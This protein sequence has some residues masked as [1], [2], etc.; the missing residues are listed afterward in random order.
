MGEGADAVY[1]GLKDFNARMRS[2]NFTYSQFEG[3]LRSIHR[4]GRKLYVTVNTVF[5]QR[6][7]DRV[8]QLLKY[9]SSIGPDGILVQDFGIITMVRDNFPSLKLHASTQ[10]NVSSARGV[11]LLSR[12]GFS[13]VVLARE[14]SLEEI[15]DIRANTN[16][17]LE[18]FVHGALCMSVSGLCLFSSYLGGKSANRGMCTQACRRYYTAEA[19]SQLAN[20]GNGG[21]YYFSP[22]DLEL[23]GEVPELVKAGVNSFKI[24]GRMKSA[25]YVG[26]VV[27]AYRLVLDAL[28]NQVMGNLEAGENSFGQAIAK[29][30]TIL[31]ND[32]A[33][34]KT[35]YFINGSENE[36]KESLDWLN[37]EQNGGTGIPLG[38]LLKVRRR[39]DESRGLIFAETLVP[40]VGDSIRL[41]KAD[42]SDRVSYKINAVEDC[43]NGSRWV[44][45]PEGFSPG[46]AVYLIQTKA[47]TRRYAPV[48]SRIEKCREPGREKA[49]LP[50]ETEEKK[51][52]GKDERKHMEE[53]PGGFYA[54]VSRIEDLYVLQSVR[55]IKVILTYSRKIIRQLLSGKPLP[56]PP[57]DIII[58]LDP[59]F[60]QAKNG[61]LEEGIPVL[62]AKGYT[63]F[64]VNNP[65]H[66]SLFRQTTEAQKDQAVLIAGPWL[67]SFNAWARSFIAKCGAEYFISPLENNRQ[68][69]EKTFYQGK[70]FQLG[71]KLPQLRNKVFITIFARPAL[72]R[73]HADLGSFYNFENFAGVREEAFRLTPAADGS[74]V[75]PCDPF[76]I[77]DK[78]P[79]LKE[80]GF[81][82]FILD[83]SDKPLKKAEY[84]N[85]MEAV[86]RAAPLPGTNRFNWKN[87]F[88]KKET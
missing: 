60:P 42:D 20:N 12:H 19:K 62:L 48:I 28:Q 8:F 64:I 13:R 23:I 7:A 85:I 72:F 24:E 69:L 79:F 11:N 37:P 22:S 57:R 88:F 76:S 36:K 35:R 83:F 44:S 15:C 75:S 84:R 10:M 67:Y 51:H 2:A 55:P 53:F 25:E 71:E 65:G 56:F 77:V 27:S 31:K 86:K 17:E 43:L 29:A 63:R 80:A 50:K 49:E 14:L 6:E 66:F 52:K 1:L 18:V 5:E 3:A 87:G 54:M 33:R 39:G 59:F 73:I 74:F 58:S 38:K 9:L 47:M 21:G 30:K 32:F 61:E 16:M 70:I 68:N 82:R 26:T 34:P 78:T 81:I 41:H 4:M 40:S 45:I 46:D